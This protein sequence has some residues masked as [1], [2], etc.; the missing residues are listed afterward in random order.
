MC[1]TIADVKSICIFEET[2]KEINMN[3]TELIKKHYQSIQLLEAIETMQRRIRYTEEALNGYGG[4][5]V[6]LR[7]KYTHEL[8][9]QTRVLKR[10]KSRYDNNN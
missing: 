5:F 9:I 10:L 3:T 1:K 7:E 2:F 8:D 4:Q 6:W